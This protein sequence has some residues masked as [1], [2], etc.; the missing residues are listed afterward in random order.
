MVLC[1]P[2]FTNLRFL[3]V[4][5]DIHQKKIVSMAYYTSN[6]TIYCLHMLT[7]TMIQLLLC[8]QQDIEGTRDLF[9][10]RATVSGRQ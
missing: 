10:N 4:I 3:L 1:Y 9:I 5:E 7:S 6:A 2:G 8:T